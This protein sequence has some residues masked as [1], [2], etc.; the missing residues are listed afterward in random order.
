MSDEWDEIG[1]VISSDYRVTAL[2]RLAEGP[3]TPSQIADE[4]DIGI[5]HV[6]RAL[7]GLRDRGLVELLVPEERKKGRVYGITTDG[8]DV[9]QQIES[10]NLVD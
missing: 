4:A 10:Q 3:A 2:K 1:F 8:N 9:W 6:S 7:K 5:A